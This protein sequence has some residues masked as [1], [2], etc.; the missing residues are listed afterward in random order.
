METIICND[1]T[2]IREEN[3]EVEGYE[4]AFSD[5]NNSYGG[6]YNRIYK[7]TKGD[8]YLV[9]SNKNGFEGVWADFDDALEFL[10]PDYWEEV[11]KD[12]NFTK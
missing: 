7:E 10:Y 5:Y 3:F 4:V 2:E 9:Y 11:K 1:G 12:I 8:N 6:G